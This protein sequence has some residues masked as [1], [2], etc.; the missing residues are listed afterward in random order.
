MALR[1]LANNPDSDAQCMIPLGSELSPEHCDGA[2]HW[3]LPHTQDAGSVPITA[4][5]GP[6]AWRQCRAPRLP[7]MG[8]WDLVRGDLPRD[9]VRSLLF[10]SEL[11]G[12]PSG[13]GGE[14]G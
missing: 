3:I 1:F 5:P 2:T 12:Q 4:T 13:G 9:S 10:P 7:C 14:K 6:R 8:I 11:C